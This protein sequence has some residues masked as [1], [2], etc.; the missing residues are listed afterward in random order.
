MLL[1]RKLTGNCIQKSMF[2]PEFPTPCSSKF[3]CRFSHKVCH[4]NT[5]LTSAFCFVLFEEKLMKSYTLKLVIWKKL[6][7][8]AEL[9]HK[10]SLPNTP[11]KSLASPFPHWDTSPSPLRAILHLC[12]QAREGAA[13]L[14]TCSRWVHQ[15]L[16]AFLHP[17]SL[18]C[19]QALRSHK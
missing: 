9:K 8:G 1:H 10:T 15:S 5:A 3:H 4:L 11:H 14:F 19:G 16:R 2:S 7:N 12:S 13:D 18:C 17:K 6:I